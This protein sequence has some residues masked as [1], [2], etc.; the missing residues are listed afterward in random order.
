MMHL[1]GGWKRLANSV[2]DVIVI[3]IIMFILAILINV[4]G[5]QSPGIDDFQV[6][7]T[8]SIYIIFILYYWVMES[9]LGKTIGKYITRTRIVKE[10]GSHPKALNVLGRTLSRFIP[11]DVFS[12]LGSPGT[13]WHDSIPKIYVISE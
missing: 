13:G 1:A 7:I 11:F 4:F 10:D 5:V 12:Y 3:Y 8:F 6:F 2:I 9:L